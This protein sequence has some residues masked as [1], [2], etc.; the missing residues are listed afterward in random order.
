MSIENEISELRA[1]ID[2][3]TNAISEHQTTP[4]YRQ[5]AVQPEQK[6]TKGKAK[7]A[8]EPEPAPEASE[9]E[10]DETVT[11]D[12]CAEAIQAAV[13]GG[14]RE[15]VVALLAEY[16]AKKLAHMDPDNYAGFYNALTKATAEA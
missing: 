12:Q 14:H 3:L 7:P 8:P 13:S 10:S 9:P 6:A 4:I 5:P 15:T 1:S 16:G 11:R 2:R